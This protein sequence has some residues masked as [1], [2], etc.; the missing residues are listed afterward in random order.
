[1]QRDVAI[2]VKIAF[3]TRWDTF[4]EKKSHLIHIDTLFSEKSRFG[5]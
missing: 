4:S 5:T 1:M 2:A 3:D